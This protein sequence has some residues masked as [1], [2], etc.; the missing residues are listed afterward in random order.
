MPQTRRERAD[1]L[2]AEEP[3]C[4][5]DGVAPGTTARAARRERPAQADARRSGPDAQHV[6]V[7]RRPKALTS[8][9]REQVVQSFMAD[10][11]MSQR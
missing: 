1:L 7:C 9:R 8:E 10:Y 2:Q 5:H 6:E 4:G 3:V 11:G